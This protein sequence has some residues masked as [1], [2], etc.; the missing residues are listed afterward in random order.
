M[1]IECDVGFCM[2]GACCVVVGEVA[3]MMLLS[4]S[5]SYIIF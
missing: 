5:K 4:K 2:V 3:E 1:V